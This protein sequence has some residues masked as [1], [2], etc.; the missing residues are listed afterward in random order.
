[1]G[2]LISQCAIR[3]VAVAAFTTNETLMVVGGQ[4]PQTGNQLTV[5]DWTF[6]W[7]IRGSLVVVQ[8]LGFIITSFWANTFLVKDKSVFATASLLRPMLDR[9]EDYGNAA[10]VDTICDMLS[11]EPETMVLYTAVKEDSH[12]GYHLE[13]VARE[14]EGYLQR[15]STTE[16]LFVR[17]SCIVAY[18]ISGVLD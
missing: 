18:G 12:K 6:I 14:G 16:F 11:D 2:F 9:F 7:L 1:M 4:Q 15:A 10:E 5:S 3:V 8:G 17:S 13:L